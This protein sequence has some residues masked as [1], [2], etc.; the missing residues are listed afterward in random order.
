LQATLQGMPA[1]DADGAPLVFD[2]DGF[3]LEDEEE[4]DP[5]LL[6]YPFDLWKP[7]ALEGNVFEPG[8]VPLNV[9]AGVLDARSAGR[10]G[11]LAK[12][13]LPHVARRARQIIPTAKGA[14]AWGWVPP[15]LLGE[16][17]KVQTDWLHDFLL[18]P[19]SIRP[20][21][22][23][24]MP[25]YNI[26]P[27]E[28]TRLVSYFAAVD[29]AGYPYEHRTRRRP[30]YLAETEKHYQEILKAASTPDKPLK[31]TRFDDA[32]RIV[33]DSNYCI[34]CHIVGDFHPQVSD[35]A[36]GPDLAEIHR[37]LR[38]TYLRNWIANPKS[39]LPY[40]GMPVNIPYDPDAP[41]LGGISQ[42]LYHGTSIEQL[43]ALVDLLMNYDQFAK[44]RS[45][46]A[47]LV[48]QNTDGD[49]EGGG[50]RAPKQ[51]SSGAGS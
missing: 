23:M 19:H 24:R 37:R 45:L 5:T 27:E 20:A 42:D 22:V 39:V 50:A 47:P 1:L 48:K 15:L 31:G 49:Q 10:G 44:G 34:K 7:A 32:M 6:E 2:E 40:T 46:V 29:D 30:S 25:R 14:E 12:Y 33:T 11:F 28:A 26:S 41:N 9:R 13:L 35:Q 3:P 36:K 38:P 8:V 21:S 16:G 4:Y 51:P 43:N 18:N 17:D